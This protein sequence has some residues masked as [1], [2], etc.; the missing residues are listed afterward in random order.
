MFNVSKLFRDEV[1]LNAPG[2][3]VLTGIGNVLEKM[4][5]MMFKKETQM[6]K[7]QGA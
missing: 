4:P 1:T 2:R 3:K 5:V 7:S 6:Y